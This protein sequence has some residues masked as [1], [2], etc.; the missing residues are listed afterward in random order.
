[1]LLDALLQDLRYSLRTLRSS[2]GFAAV[3]ILSL[4]LGIGANTAIFSLID[5]VMLKY[6]PVSHP[7]ELLQVTGAGQNASFTNP[8]WEQVRERQDIFSG[9]FAS[10]RLRLNLTKGG[11]ARYAEGNFASGAIFSTLGV[12]PILGRTFTLA[13]DKRGCPAQAVLSYDFWQRQYGASASVLEKAISLDGHPFQVLGVLQSGFFGTDVGIAVDVYVPICNEPIIRGERSALDQRSSWWLRIVGRP[14]AGIGPQQVRSRLKSLAPEIYE[15]TVPQDW[16]PEYKDNYRRRTFEILPVAN[17]MSYTRA[18]YRPALLTLMVVV[19]LVL[20]IACANVANLLLAR[21]AVRQKEIAIR[22]AIGAARTRLIRQLLTESVLIA[23]I[24]A[25]LGI[26]FAM[27]ASRGL[28]SFLNTTFNHTSLDL[29]IDTRVLGFT[30]AVAIATGILFG[31]APAWRG[32]RI[33]PQSAMKETSRG[34]TE[35]RGRLGFGKILVVAQV[36]LSLVLLV[37]AGLL[38]GTFRS[39]ATMNPGFEPDHVLIVSADLRNAKYAQERRPEIFEQLLDR[40]RAIPGVRSATI[41]NDTPISG[42][43]WNGDIV[44]DGFVAKN[45][46]D[47]VVW[48]YESYPKLFETLGM[49]FIAGRDF[50]DRDRPGAPAVIVIN[51]T[52]AKKFFGAA[53]PIGKTIRERGVGNKLGEPE[54]II[55]L[56]KDA[57]YNSLREAVL[58][59]VY[60]PMRQRKGL[61]LFATFELRAQAA[62]ADLI[63]SVKSVIGDYNGD[64]V[65]SFRTLSTQ[66]AESLNRERLLATLSGFF[67]ALAL[68]LAAIGLYGV[69]SYNVARR[70]GE[71]G[72]R[73]ALGAEQAR[74]LRMVLREVTLI[75]A[76]GLIIGSAAALATTRFVATF[77]YG[78]T[79]RDPLTIAAAAVVLATVAAAAGYLPA[80]RASRLDPMAAL[81]EE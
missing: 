41:V 14:K 64:L 49:Q 26:V 11:E 24:G 6:L 9:I 53:N 8:I 47:A 20:L 45:E 75:V 28:V 36:S 80:R 38:I 23:S 13:D 67:G 4:A 70:R 3:A 18:Q 60:K 74:V 42:N 7:E 50:D 77:L 12:Q 25:L 37:G 71:I 63:P 22:L 59:V 54:E 32:T 57:K 31:S 33:S 40:L 15:A 52:M 66:I 68:L 51:E 65:L 34:H 78:M 43:T 21:A 55:G 30:A 35:G 39:L 61:P 76:I 81:R 62:A 10:S 56:V 69:M 58:P 44:V 19:G 46:D 1:M 16:A 29:S 79:P 48:F 2:P 72:I 5:A 27:W 73:M 17:G